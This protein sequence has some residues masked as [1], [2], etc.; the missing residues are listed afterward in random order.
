M[1]GFIQF[2]A[3]NNG[4]ILRIVV[5]IILIVIGIVGLQDAA[6]IILV[7]VGLVPLLAGIFDFCV[8]A[9]LA[10]LPVQGPEIRKKG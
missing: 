4:R 3:S 1:N 2:M 9:P 8:F 7:I 10:G 6:R 5:G